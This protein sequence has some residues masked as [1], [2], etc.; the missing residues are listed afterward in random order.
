MF[1]PSR[2]RAR[3]EAITV[4]FDDFLATLGEP[5]FSTGIRVPP[6]VGP[7][8]RILAARADLTTG[9][10]VIGL[11]QFWS[12]A[13]YIL[14]ADGESPPPAPAYPEWRPVVA[15]GWRF[16][17]IDPPTWRVT[18]EPLANF[19][20][21]KGPFDQDSFLQRDTTGPALVYE[22][23][24]FPVLPPL[25]GYLGLSAYTPPPIRGQ[26]VELLRDIRFPQAQHEFFA[27]AIPIDHPTTVRLYVDIQ[28][29]NPQTRSKV[30]FAT[31]L[32]AQ[33][34]FFVSGLVPEERFL[35]DFPNAIVHAA[36][37]SLLFD[38]IGGDKWP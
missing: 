9:D 29:T 36:G 10:R 35:Q 6:V 32:S 14:S 33:Q 7:T 12:I 1:V 25:P 31:S 30:N 17:D 5:P 21:P 8:Y 19:S 27:L 3:D 18:L 23:A 38:R 20:R 2:R 28:Q 16:V 26:T 37:G 24:A 22:T 11:R 15:P 13:Q 34:L 4:G